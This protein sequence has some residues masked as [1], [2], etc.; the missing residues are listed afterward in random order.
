MTS[1][2]RNSKQKKAREAVIISAINYFTE[3]GS[4]R[5]LKSILN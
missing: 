1:V 4:L 3:A 2:D 5:G